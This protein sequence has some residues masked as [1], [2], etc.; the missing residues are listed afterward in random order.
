MTASGDESPE[1]QLKYH[2]VPDPA[3]RAAKN[4][5]PTK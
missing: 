1:T 5:R 2:R 4:R 3:L